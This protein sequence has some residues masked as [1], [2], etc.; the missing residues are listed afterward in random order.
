MTFVPHVRGEHG[1]TYDWENNQWTVPI[2]ASGSQLLKL[3]KLPVQF[4]LGG[5]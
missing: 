2:N 3:G 1:V 4:N 5:R